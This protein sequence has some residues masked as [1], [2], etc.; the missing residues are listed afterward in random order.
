MADLS[1]FQGGGGGSTVG[2]VRPL[3]TNDNN[4]LFLIGTEEWLRTG[5]IETN[6]ANYPDARTSA[7]P[8]GT[9]F[10]AGYSFTAQ[11]TLPYGITT[12][13]LHVYMVGDNSDTIYRYNLDG[14][15][16]GFSFSVSAQNSA[17]RGL[18][19]DGVNLCML[20]NTGIYKYTLD[21]IYTGVFYSV[22]SFNNNPVGLGWTGTEFLISN[23]SDGTVYRVSS[24]GAYLGVLFSDSNRLQLKGLTQNQAT[25]NI[26]TVANDN[27]VFEYTSAGVATGFSFSTSSFETQPSALS[28]LS[29]T[30]DSI[31]VVGFSGDDATPFLIEPK[32]FVG[33]GTQRF[34]A[35][36]GL[37][38]YVRIK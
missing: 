28:Y 1:L 21:G 29:T 24:A 14:S 25:G 13:G 9:Q 2:D 4:G 6:T 11:D 23:F 31:Y 7:L 19:F 33:I 37:P 17:P 3:Y 26:Y 10:G 35:N 30:P 8:K 22:T 32:P 18:V 38:F 15:Y 16:T 27:S 34:Q 12:D 36:T 20:G 5:V